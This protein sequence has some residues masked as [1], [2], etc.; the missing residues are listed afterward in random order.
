MKTP[1]R[2]V[3]FYLYLVVLIS[4]PL[5]FGT[6]EDWSYAIMEI[7]IG[8]G[9]LLLILERRQDVF[10]YKAPGL[11]LLLMLCGWMLIQALPLPAFLVKLL[12]P[13]AYR[14]YRQ[15]LEPLGTGSWIPLSVH[16][17][18]T[19]Q[20]CLRFSSY[21]LFYWLAVQLLVDYRRLKRTLVVI[22]GFAGL[23]A[24]LT[25]IDFITKHMGYPLSPGKIFWLRPSPLAMRAVGP[26]VNHNHYAGLMEMIFPLMLSLFVF[27][28][29]RS[30]GR[31]FRQKTADFFMHR[32]LARSLFYGLIIILIGASVF[33]SLSRGGAISLI[34]SLIVFS[35]WMVIKTQ[36][37]K[38]GLVLAVVLIGMLALTGAQQ[39][40]AL[41]DRFELI[42]SESGQIDSGR[43]E[44]WPV[45]M[46]MIH[47]FPICGSGM[48]TTQYIYQRY[49]TDLHNNILEHVHN[50]YLG[51]LSTGGIILAVIMASA[52]LKIFF[53]SFLNHR[54][55]HDRFS[56]YLFIGCWTAVLAI[57]IHS[58]VDFNLQIGANGLYFF[59]VLALAVSA[60]H[61]RMHA[62]TDGT[63]QPTLLMP[64]I[65]KRPYWLVG[66]MLFIGAVLIV[67]GGTLLANYHFADYKQTV[68]RP[69]L[70]KEAHRKINQAA[71]KA[72]AV[73]PLN[74]VYHYYIAANSAVL[75]KD[76]DLAVRHYMKAL[77]YSP[78]DS[79]ILQEAAFFLN[80]QGRVGPAEK[81]MQAA[82]DA[83]PANIS[84]HL[85]YAALLL[86][87]DQTE[88]G[89][90]MLRNMMADDPKRTEDCL[91]VMA[92]HGVDAK[93]IQT[94]LPERVAAYLAFGDYLADLGLWENAATAYRTAMDYIPREKTV[95]K[96]YFMT[97]Y[98][99]FMQRRDK[100]A[101]LLVI[102][103][104]L[105]YFP[106]DA[107]L[108]RLAERLK[109]VI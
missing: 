24:F 39:W 44:R 6:V 30:Q 101:A 90:L 42:R 56:Q 16:P 63:W 10:F 45:I 107:Y 12:S 108:Q 13:E 92:W 43:L 72:V 103:Q 17:K 96:K 19:L 59:F 77:R 88:K 87:Q 3:P 4:S 49:R 29:P 62:R 57:L 31:N 60:A 95:E 46:E 47:A 33:M 27:Y 69:D 51:F 74:P 5:A 11:S 100:E 85:K 9:V 23:L 37:K 58:L 82:I 15:A 76:K 98:R 106:D 99:F 7:L 1:F 104:A 78:S 84:G 89:L 48:G 64:A 52:L 40:D 61:T 97:I 34:V 102:Q 65:L 54:Q 68:W 109:P 91:T 36:K 73:D 93:Q 66:S 86:E 94:A 32:Y 35:L 81:L 2:N 8:L 55:R 28:Q 70:S 21:V 67:H 26:Y 22:A 75:P 14:I 25:I 71:V 53:V 80:R 20:E 83:Y 18:T 105:D 38:S 50:D 79:R 41:F